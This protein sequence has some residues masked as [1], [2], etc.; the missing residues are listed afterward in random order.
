MP[1]DLSPSAGMVRAHDRDRFLATLF[2]PAEARDDLFA[3]YAFNIEIASVR[4]RVVEPMMGRIRL[5]WWRDAIDTGEGGGHPLAGEVLRAVA[6]RGLDRQA[7]GRMIEARES[8]LDDA[9]HA[10]VAALEAYAEATAGELA[11]LSLGVLGARSEAERAAGRHVG[12]AWALIGLLRAVPFMASHGR[13]ALPLDR[14]AAHGVHSRDVLAGTASPGLAKVVEE[15]AAR[16]GEHLARS[17]DHRRAVA[18]RALPAL[19]LGV[20]AERYAQ[21]LARAGFNPFAARPPPPGTGTPRMA[22]AALTG[23]Y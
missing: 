18:R 23:R 22:L 7:L 2:A 13:L 16:A 15:I 12:I 17:R 21:A 10:D 1:N 8:D 3:L 11:G 20:Q 9:P 4:E 14:L 19:L 5:Q 6:G